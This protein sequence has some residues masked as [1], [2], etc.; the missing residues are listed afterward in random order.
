LANFANDTVVDLNSVFAGKVPLKHTRSVSTA[1]L[2]FVQPFLRG[3][4]EAVTLEPLTQ[5]ERD[6]VYDIRSY[7][8]FRKEFYVNIA[9][10]SATTAGGGGTT[11]GGSGG[12]T[13]AGSGGQTLDL[14]LAVTTGLGVTTNQGYLPTLLRLAQVITQRANVE[15]FE[16]FKKRFDAL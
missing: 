3:G 9:A 6:L 16:S 2:E 8:R 5:A 11:V 10:G 7:A 12:V 14:S 13:G 1:T 4:G 15:A